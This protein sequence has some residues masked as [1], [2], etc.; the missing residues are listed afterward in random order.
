MSVFVCGSLHYDVVVNAPHLPRL[1][2]T[3]T[4]AAVN[5]IMGGKGGNQAVASARMG[6]KTAFAGRVGDDPYGAALLKGLMDAGVETSQVQSE[7][8]ASGMSVAIVEPDGGYGAVIVSAANLNIDPNLIDIPANSN[9][10]LLQNEVPEAVNLVVALKARSMGASVIL[11]AAPARPMGGDLLGA[12]DIL[13]VNRV[14]AAD[15]LAAREAALDPL[16]AA[17]ALTTLGPRTV[18]LT[19][20]GDGLVLHDG[21]TAAHHPGHPVEVVSTHGAGDAFLGAL[22]AAHSRGDH[23]EEAARFGQATAALHVSTPVSQRST[24]TPQQVE[25]LMAQSPTR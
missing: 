22:A 11:N 18:I 8:G 21:V 7:S 17:R 6:A 20:G 13:V 3:V 10:V 25:A 12:I 14:E 2:E 9:V 23:L 16:G 5:Y 1:D 24:I 15:L 4:G 19:L